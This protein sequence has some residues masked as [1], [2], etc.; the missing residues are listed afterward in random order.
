M[1]NVSRVYGQ[2][3]ITLFIIVKRIAMEPKRTEGSQDRLQP[4]RIRNVW[5]RSLKDFFGF[6]VC[7]LM[8]P[9]L[10]L[11]AWAS[12]MPNSL[13]RT[14]GELSP[15]ASVTH[16]GIAVLL[17][18]YGHGND[19]ATFVGDSQTETY[20][21]WCLSPSKWVG[22]GADTSANC[23][24][25]GVYTFHNG[26]TNFRPFTET[27][28]QLWDAHSIGGGRYEAFDCGGDVCISRSIWEGREMSQ[29][30]RTVSVGSSNDH[31]LV[32]FAFRM[33]P[34]LI[35]YSTGPKLVVASH[36]ESFESV[37]VTIEATQKCSIAAV[38]LSKNGESSTAIAWVEDCV[39]NQERNSSLVHWADLGRDQL[40]QHSTWSV[41][42]GWTVDHSSPFSVVQGRTIR[43]GVNLINDP[44]SGMSET[45][46]MLRF[47]EPMIPDRQ[48]VVLSSH[49]SFPQIGSR[50]PNMLDNKGCSL[51]GMS[52]ASRNRTWLVFGD[53]LSA[54]LKKPG[55]A[56]R[57]VSTGQP[58]YSI[59]EISIPE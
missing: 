5:E 18:K 53:G 22:S 11:W 49:R 29:Q 35:A 59:C 14:H 44:E 15:S 28:R 3:V 21:D 7:F 9:F 12:P 4:V 17:P 52:L 48:G 57:I 27:F 10:P 16:D 24:S 50:A 58:I 8:M 36:R 54:V 23:H 33:S 20:P 40:N 30:V 43:V 55:I 37:I 26:L 19:W 1:R 56:G 13:V 47:H 6:V 31:P 38:E 42:P 39:F 25:L 51:V 32:D 34:D 41:P 2:V 45:E 46:R